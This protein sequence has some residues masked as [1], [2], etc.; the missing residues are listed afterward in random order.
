[1]ASRRGDF[2]G[3]VLP[4][5]LQNRSRND[6]RLPAPVNHHGAL[7]SDD[8]LTVL[9]E[10]GRFHGH[11]AD[12]GTRPG[13]AFLQHLGLRAEVVAFQNLILH[14]YFIPSTSANTL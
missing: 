14:P 1:M 12:A 3:C 7:E 11:D 6:R 4:W 8:D 5:S 10:A 9:I 13:F 2:M